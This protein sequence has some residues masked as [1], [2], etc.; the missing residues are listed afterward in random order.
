MLCQNSLH[1]HGGYTLY[2][3]RWV[4]EYWWVYFPAP[5]HLLYEQRFGMARVLVE[6]LDMSPIVVA[7]CNNSHFLIQGL[8]PQTLSMITK[9][10]TTA[11]F[12]SGRS[13]LREICRL[14]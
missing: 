12:I 10:G 14:N 11:M 7:P 4:R 5:L 8:S 3:E 2:G 6:E 13:L 9:D 1:F